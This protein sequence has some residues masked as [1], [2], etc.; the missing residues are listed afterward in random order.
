MPLKPG[1]V[2]GTYEIAEA[3]GADPPTT[4]PFGHRKEI[5]SHSTGAVVVGRTKSGWFRQAAA[6]RDP[7]PV[8]GFAPSWSPDGQ[9]VAFAFTSVQ[10]GTRRL[11]RISANG[12]GEPQPVT[13]TQVRN[14]SYWSRDGTAI[15]FLSPSDIWVVSLEDEAER[16]LTDFSGK[17][18]NLGRYALA[19]DGQYLYFTWEEDLGDI[20]VMDVVTE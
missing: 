15:Y 6:I 12:K 4:Y 7:S 18:G 5:R 9:W 14:R 8:T 10:D 17:R 19:M 3:I 20:W 2:L 13:K 11:W 16:P 1:T